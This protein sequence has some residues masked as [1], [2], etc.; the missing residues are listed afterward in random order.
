MM[1]VGYRTPPICLTVTSIVCCLHLQFA[2]SAVPICVS[3]SREHGA[4]AFLC[5]VWLVRERVAADKENGADDAFPY[6]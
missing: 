1:I 2:Y 5:F 6:F 3:A 4:C